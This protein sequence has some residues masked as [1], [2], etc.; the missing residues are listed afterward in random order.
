MGAPLLA[1]AKSIY[2][3]CFICKRIGLPT[4]EI[5]LLGF[6]LVL[7]SEIFVSGLLICRRLQ[8]GLASCRTD[9]SDNLLDSSKTNCG[10][11]RSFR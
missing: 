1:P 9:I 4:C 2:Y 3:K 6:W 5:S 7:E 11:G 8:N 10:R